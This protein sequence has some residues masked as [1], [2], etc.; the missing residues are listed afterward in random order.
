MIF[1]ALRI[2][3]EAIALVQHRH[4]VIRHASGL[5][6]R[7]TNE[8]AQPVEMRFD[9]IEQLLR[10]MDAQQIGQRGIGAVEIH[11]GRIRRDHVGN[12]FSNDFTLGVHDDLL[13]VLVAF[14]SAPCAASAA[15]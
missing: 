10:Q 12:G 13:F 2:A 1:D 11:A 7:P 3:A 15:E 14:P 9:M 8:A 6:E 4:V 5:I